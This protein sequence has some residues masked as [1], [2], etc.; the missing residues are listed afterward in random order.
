MHRFRIAAN[1]SP[2]YLRYGSSRSL[3]HGNPAGSTQTE[4]C[5]QMNNEAS[6]LDVRGLN[7]PLPVLKAKKAMTGLQAG[8]LLWVETTDPLSAVDIP[9]F[10]S[11]DG[12]EL[13]TV[14]Q[15]EGY[16]RYL[17]RK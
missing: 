11:N 10:C 1:P 3:G 4:K 16:Q 13:M 12:H 17:I 14:E 5:Q 7:C 15:A 6:I 9:A 2:R 8:A